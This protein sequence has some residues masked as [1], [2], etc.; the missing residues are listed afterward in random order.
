MSGPTGGLT[1]GLTIRRV[2]SSDEQDVAAYVRI[3]CAVTPDSPDS[4]ERVAW[5]D[6][7]Y[8]GDVHRFLAD[9]GGETVATATTGRIHVYGPGFERYWL[10]LWVLPGVRGTGI[11]SELL[12]VLS[13]AARAAGKTGFE[14]I[15][16]ESHPEGLRFLAARGF[17]ETDRD[18]QVRLDLR[19]VDTPPV[20]PPPGIALVTLAER[21]GL[22]PAVHAIAAE[23]YPDIPTGGEPMDPGPLD[24]FA[25]RE[26]GRVG[27]PADAFHVALD[28]ASGEAV[29]YASLVLAPGST[30][31]AFHAMTA[32]RPAFRGRGIATALK[33]ATIAWA[34]GHGLEALETS[35]DVR[36]TPMRAVNAALGYEPLPDLVG[37]RGPLATVR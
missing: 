22:V 26:V 24:E 2:D 37:L 36:N 17:V 34:I 21:P 25:A 14:T 20:V 4:A 33:R 35:N 13:D 7:T 28:E 23:T 15:L 19:G 9:Q 11:G 10:G 1:G 30:T 27:V 12:A 3:R 5:E 8:P 29:G 32:V 31:M 6:A 18:R 16:S